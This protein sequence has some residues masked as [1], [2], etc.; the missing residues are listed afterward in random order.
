MLLW[1]KVVEDILDQV[2]VYE[3]NWTKMGMD[4]YVGTLKTLL[5]SLRRKTEDK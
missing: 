3:D 4:G 2:F 1:E 5:L